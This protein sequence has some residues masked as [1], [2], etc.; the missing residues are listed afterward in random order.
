MVT[1]PFLPQDRLVAK[2]VALG[3]IREFQPP[4]DHIGL[5]LLAPFQSVATDDG[6]FEYTRGLTAG[7]APARAED[8]E[9]ELAQKDDS[10]GVGRA[11][12]I[13]WALKDHYDPSDVSRYREAMVI[14]D[15]NTTA[16]LLTLPLTVG[17]ILDGFQD[18]IAR[19]TAIRRRKLDNR[20][21][22]LITQACWT[23]KIV[24]NDS[25][26]VFSVDYGRPAAQ[27]PVTSGGS[28]ACPSGHYWNDPTNGDPIGDILAWQDWFYNVHGVS[29]ARC[30]ITKRIMHGLL[31]NARF[32]T[33]LTGTNPLYTVASWGY[34]AVLARISAATG[35]E[36]TTYDSVYR[37]RPIGSNTMTNNRFTN[38]HTALFLPSQQDLD[39][40]DDSIGFGKT[41]TSPHPEG[42]WTPGYYEWEQETVD[43]WGRDVGTGIKAFPVFPHLNLTLAVDVLDPA[44]TDPVTGATPGLTYTMPPY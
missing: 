23:G 7:L 33:L 2:E 22:W 17:S 32:Q 42:N 12:V 11:S 25:K 30:I 41:L 13:D 14:S 35:I 9:S 39:A 27:T 24:Y 15:N 44:Y 1:T 29:L 28:S 34:D 5:A 10:I 16:Q 38:P 3:V 31:N 20:I 26:I 8:A 18:R 43:P 37:T 40:L 19:D 4:Q 21:E 6:I 36:F